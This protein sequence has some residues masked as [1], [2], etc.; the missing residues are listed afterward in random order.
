MR[1]L[2]MLQAEKATTAMMMTLTVTMVTRLVAV[3]Q[4]QGMP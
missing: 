4:Q 2:L 1:K 3:L